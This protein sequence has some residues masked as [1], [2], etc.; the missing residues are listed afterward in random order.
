[1]IACIVYGVV[2][3]A[4]LAFYGVVVAVSGLFL[5]GITVAFYVAV[6]PWLRF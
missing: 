6:R 5:I 1:M 3:G 4:V 2:S